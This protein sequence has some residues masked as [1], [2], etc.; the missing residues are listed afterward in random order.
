MFKK[1]F[2]YLSI[3]LINIIPYIIKS[4]NSLVIFKKRL[5]SWLLEKEVE[6][7]EDLFV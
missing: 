5:K 7:V 4:A 2:L 3:K 6:E 1:C